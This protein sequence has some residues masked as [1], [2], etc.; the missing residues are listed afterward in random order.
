MRGRWPRPP[1]IGPA[2]PLAGRSTWSV[3]ALPSRGGRD[4]LRCCWPVAG[5]HDKLRAARS[6]SAT[7]APGRIWLKRAGIGRGCVGIIE[8]SRSSRRRATGGM[9]S[10]SPSADG[11]GL[12]KPTSRDVIIASSDPQV[13]KSSDPLVQQSSDPQVQ[14]EGSWRDPSSLVPRRLVVAQEP[15]AER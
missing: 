9:S 5:R 10:W 3:G 6:R 12:D 11:A 4:A 15:D 2:G 1:G 7:G 13:H 14:H 8:S